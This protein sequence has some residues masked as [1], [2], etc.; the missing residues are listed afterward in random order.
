MIELIT[1][2]LLIEI[3]LINEIKILNSYLI[4]KLH[5]N[6]NIKINISFIGLNLKYTKKYFLLI[7]R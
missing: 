2:I 5:N 1:Y 7:I 3:I 4:E 6:H